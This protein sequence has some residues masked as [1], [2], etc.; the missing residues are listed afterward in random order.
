MVILKQPV[1]QQHQK[2]ITPY[3]LAILDRLKN[4]YYISS[5]NI[6]ST[7]VQVPVREGSKEPTGFS[8][9]ARNL[10]QFT[11]TP[12]GLTN[13]PATLQRTIDRVLGVDLENIVWCGLSR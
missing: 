7:F 8:V 9:P 12:V 4:A 5:I 2:E 13:K 10:F 6:K 11:R 1:Q 3:I